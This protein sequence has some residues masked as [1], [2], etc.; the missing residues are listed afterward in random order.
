MKDAENY[1]L[2][3]KQ[4]VIINDLRVLVRRRK[5]KCSGANVNIGGESVI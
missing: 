5:Y 2:R 4:R 3:L 1:S